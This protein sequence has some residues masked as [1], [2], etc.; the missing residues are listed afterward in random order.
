[1]RDTHQVIFLGH[2]DGWTWD[3]EEE[4]SGGNDPGLSTRDGAICWALSTA[5]Q[6][7]WGEEEKSVWTTKTVVPKGQPGRG[8]TASLD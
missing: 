3:R 4:G 7:V 8:D 5:R 2:G 1:M 6:A